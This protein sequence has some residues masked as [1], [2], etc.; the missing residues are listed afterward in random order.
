MAPSFELDGFTVRLIDTP[1]FGSLVDS[2]T[3]INLLR[4]M[5][6]IFAEEGVHIDEQ[7]VPIL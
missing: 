7:C 6:D 5:N 4:G 3:N 1:G 2:G